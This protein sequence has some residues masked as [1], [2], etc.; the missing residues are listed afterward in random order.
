MQTYQYFSI[1]G[2]KDSIQMKALVALVFS[3]E[4][5]STGLAGYHIENALIENFADYKPLSYIDWSIRTSVM[6][7]FTIA[8]VVN[9]FFVRRIYLLSKKNIWLSLAIAILA[10]VRPAFGFAAAGL[11]ITYN[12]WNA[13]KNHAQ[14]VMVT[15]LSLGLFVD[16]VIS[17]CV[18]FYLL[19][20]RSTTIR[21][22]INILLRYT[23]NTGAI[24]SVFAV[25]ELVVLAAFPRTVAFLGL[26]QVQIQL[27][28]NCFL[29]NLNARQSIRDETMSR[30]TFG[31]DS[32][33]R[34]TLN[35]P[36]TIPHTQTI[37]SYEADRGS[38]RGSRATQ[39][40]IP[41][42]STARQTRPVTGTIM[43]P[44][45]ANS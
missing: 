42:P 16:C 38:R 6:V 30:V 11:S 43:R 22:I 35:R 24:L 45:T 29:T 37:G 21:P 20:G 28:A 4:T 15:G 32:V 10:T 23:I 9:Q 3:L 39:G 5:A 1:Y 26:F 33:Q 34:F 25:L 36:P 31:S 17:L 12:N 40:K 41:R 7:G 44:S 18:A 27:Y 14:W 2:L 19:K 8:F 13:F